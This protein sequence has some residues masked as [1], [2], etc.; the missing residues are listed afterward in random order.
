VPRNS[1]TRPSATACSHAPL[2]CPQL[3][4]LAHLQDQDSN[5]TGMDA[6]YTYIYPPILS[7]MMIEYLAGGMREAEQV[8]ANI[9]FS[10]ETASLYHK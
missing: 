10:K 2:F 4:V 1:V 3:D 6:C 7:D 9:V 5:L 8:F